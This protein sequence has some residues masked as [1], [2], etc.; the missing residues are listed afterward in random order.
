MA[1]SIGG[2]LLNKSTGAVSWGVTSLSQIICP[3]LRRLIFGSRIENDDMGDRD[4]QFIPVRH[5][6]DRPVPVL[7]KDDRDALDLLFPNGVID[8]HDAVAVHPDVHAGNEI[9]HHLETQL[10]TIFPILSGPLKDADIRILQEFHPDGDLSF[11]SSLKNVEDRI[12]EFVQMFPQLSRDQRNLLIASLTSLNESAS[13]VFARAVRVND[14]SS[15]LRHR[16]ASGARAKVSER[17]F[18]VENE[19]IDEKKMIVDEVSSDDI[20]QAIRWLCFSH[21]FQA[22]QKAEGILNFPCGDLKGISNERCVRELIKR[23]PHHEALIWTVYYE[24]KKEKVIGLDDDPIPEPYQIAL[25]D[26]QIQDARVVILSVLRNRK[27][28]LTNK[29]LTKDELNAVC[30][31]F[32]ISSDLL[33]IIHDQSMQLL[34]KYKE[35]QGAEMIPEDQ[36]VEYFREEPQHDLDVAVYFKVRMFIQFVRETIRGAEKAKALDELHPHNPELDGCLH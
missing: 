35:N 28:P 29:V 2:W 5:N 21:H 26:G 12:L 19:L 34:H 31:K 1:Y 27:N 17:S 6:P 7:P 10:S 20:Q 36:V 18:V 3:P 24:G 30:E 14:V 8:L 23:F 25:L 13:P 33:D 4:V 15:E 22:I 11:L 32:D 9:F 16:F